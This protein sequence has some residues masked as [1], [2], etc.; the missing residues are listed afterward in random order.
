MVQE[1]G[2]EGRIIAGD[3]PDGP[4]HAK[5]IDNDGKLPD[6]HVDQISQAAQVITYSRD[7]FSVLTAMRD[8]VSTIPWT[9]WPES[10]SPCFQGDTHLL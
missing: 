10:H 3:T 1:V 5:P 6:G 7:I 9:E 8:R 4:M 2:I